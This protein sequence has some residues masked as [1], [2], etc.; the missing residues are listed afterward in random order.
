[1]NVKMAFTPLNPF[2]APLPFLPRPGDAAEGAAAIGHAWK[3]EI[4]FDPEADSHFGQVYRIGDGELISMMKKLIRGREQI[5]TVSAYQCKLFSVQLTQM[6]LNHQFVVFET[7]G[8][9]WSVEKNSD[10]IT[11]Q[12]SKKLEFVRD[13]YRRDLRPTPIIR[14]KQD[15]GR[16]TMADLVDYLWRKDE[17][18]KKYNL[19]TDNCKH[20]AKRIFDEVAASKYL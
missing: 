13:R 3:S 2:G 16:R 19:A 17:L 5:T 7:D 20:F 4:Y 11:I 10:G 12:R 18:N 6:L 8:W 9:W 14:M 15:N 1:L